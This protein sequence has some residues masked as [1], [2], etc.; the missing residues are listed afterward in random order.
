M[1]L[2][3][4]SNPYYPG[5]AAWNGAEQRFGNAWAK[6]IYM[7]SLIDDG[8]VTLR[9]T[10]NDAVQAERG[11]DFARPGSDSTLDNFIEQVT[12]D[13]LAAPLDSLNDQLG[14]AAWNVLRNPFV[15]VVVVAVVV[16]FLWPKIRRFIA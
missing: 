11:R 9:N 15:L 6:R 10:L 4:E 12:T 8:G 14:K 13:P 2:A 1:M 3:S 7:A 5:N 16:F